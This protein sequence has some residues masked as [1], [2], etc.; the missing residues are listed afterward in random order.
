MSQVKVSNLK[1]VTRGEC[2]K[3]RIPKTP[4]ADSENMSLPSM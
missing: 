4:H 2:M 3:Q 1:A